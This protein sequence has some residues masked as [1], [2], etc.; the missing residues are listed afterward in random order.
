MNS[1]IYIPTQVRP[2]SLVEHPYL[3][4]TIQDKVCGQDLLIE[5]W[6]QN[7][8]IIISR[9]SFT[10]TLN[11]LISSMYRMFTIWKWLRTCSPLFNAH[12][13]YVLFSSIWYFTQVSVLTTTTSPSAFP[14]TCC[15]RWFFW[16]TR[17]TSDL[18]STLGRNAKRR[19]RISQTN[20]AVSNMTAIC[21]LRWTM[22]CVL[23]F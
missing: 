13:L 1:Q 6:N 21:K 20:M 22:H 8:R 18:P 23:S 4:T 7:K 12:L 19:F 5:G 10:R 16:C 15:G 11:F 9:D 17:G 14:L 2:C 3:T